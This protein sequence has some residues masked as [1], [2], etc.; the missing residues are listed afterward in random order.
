MVDPISAKPVRPARVTKVEAPVAAP[1]GARIATVE[2]DAT[3]SLSV[4]ALA[5]ELAAKPPVDAERVAKIRQA[6]ANQTYPILP[7][8]VADRLLA[9]KLNWRPQ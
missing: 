4:Q 2:D 3:P 9:L 6:I 1:A 7:E 8:T 5:Q